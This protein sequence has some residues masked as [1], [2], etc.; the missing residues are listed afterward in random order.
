M[1]DSATQHAPNDLRTIAHELA[2]A[3]RAPESNEYEE[4]GT[5][6]QLSALYSALARAQANFA[7][8]GRDEQV[9]VLNADRKKLYSFRYAPLELIIAATRPALAAEGLACFMAPSGGVLRLVLSHAMGGRL[10]VTTRFQAKASEKDY[11]GQLT[12]LRRYMYSAV[13]NVA[14]DEDLDA[15]P[16]QSRGD[17]AS[18]YSDSPRG[19][20]AASTNLNAVKAHLRNLGAVDM[21]TAQALAAKALQ[22]EIIESFEHLTVEQCRAILAMGASK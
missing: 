5:E 14:A 1:T 12:Y 2:S 18:S 8:F 3:Y 11:G 15:M 10:V 17:T 7:P 21:R 22:G 20:V 16:E 9:D 4:R 19:N 13:L 6:S